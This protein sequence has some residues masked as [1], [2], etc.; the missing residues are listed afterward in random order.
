MQSAIIEPACQLSKG[1]LVDYKFKN[2]QTNKV[3]A[4]TTYLKKAGDIV[5]GCGTY[6]K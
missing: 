2:P 1:N 6:K 4:K 3:E 5:V